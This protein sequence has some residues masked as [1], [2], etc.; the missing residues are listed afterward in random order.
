M[1]KLQF[2]Y[3]YVGII[4]I[5]AV[6]LFAM[7][8]FGPQEKCSDVE[9]LGVIK[10]KSCNESS[11]DN[12]QD[13]VQGLNSQQIEKLTEQI[14]SVESEQNVS[15][16]MHN[17]INQLES[18]LQNLKSKTETQNELEPVASNIT[19]FN[20]IG[21]WSVEGIVAGY[22]FLA[23]IDLY[24]DGTYTMTV[25]EEGVTN[26][27]SGEYSIDLLNGIVIIYSYSFG[28]PSIYYITNIQSNSISLSNP[29]YDEYYELTRQ[30]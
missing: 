14:K 17:K 1:S 9:V 12:N 21:S 4:G 29:I 11:L 3:K 16:K 18:E 5:I 20:F 23:K 13:I 19:S 6:A 28:E 8:Q 25:F 30:R 7:M 15:E 27:D 22:D 10:M 24:D 26:T 2:N